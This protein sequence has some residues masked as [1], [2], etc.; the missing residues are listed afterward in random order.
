MDREEKYADAFRE[1]AAELLSDMEEVILSLETDPRD[2]ELINRL[3]RI[4]HT[5]KGSGAMFGFQKV[6]DF[7]HHLETMLDLVRAGSMTVTPALISLLLQSRDHIQVM[8]YSHGSEPEGSAEQGSA[9]LAGLKTLQGQPLQPPVS[10]SGEPVHPGSITAP[11]LV[12][13]AEEPAV[14][15][16]QKDKAT[17]NQQSLSTYRLRI[18]LDPKVM[19]SGLD[20][21]CLLREL[22][23]MGECSISAQTDQVPWLDEINPEECYFYW[24]AIINTAASREDL[25]MV[26]L[27]VEDESQISITRLTDELDENG[28]HK[29]LGEILVER[30]DISKEDVRNILAKQKRAGELMV[31]AGLVTPGKIESA[32]AEQKM[33]QQLRG[34]QQQNTDTIRVST[35][36]L[37]RLINLVGEMVITQAQLSQTS[38]RYQDTDLLTPVENIERL[39]NELRDCALNIRMFP[40][41][42]TFSKFRR[43]VHDL[44]ASLGKEAEL[45]TEGGE[46]E[47]DKTVIER[48]HDPLIHLIRN[49]LD[50]GLESPEERLKAGKPACGTIRLSAGQSGGE[51]IITIEDDGAG[52]DR[53][54]IRAKGIEQGLISESE[55]LTDQQVFNL[56]FLPGFSTASKITDVSGRGVG[57]DVV[58]REISK[59]RGSVDINSQRGRGTKTSIHLPLT[60]AI[61]EGLLV[62]VG[63]SHYVVPLTFVQECV[64]LTSQEVNRAH[65][66]HVI[67]L[68]GEIIPYIRLREVFGTCR[69]EESMP[70][71]EYVVVAMVEGKR[72]GL[73][74]DTIIGDY[75][76][77]I[78]SLG[79]IYEHTEGISGATILGDGTI[80]LIVD[81]RQLIECAY[82][83]EREVLAET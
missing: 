3:F 8:L 82:R 38:N 4:M 66:R 44:S 13:P 62:A 40:I 79:R 7:A 31:E 48:I 72:V 53:E 33:V 17:S 70:P 42:G 10:S 50:H 35:K 19:L 49:S 43:L 25:E 9:I 68:R 34:S 11:A 29:K 58:R 81:V 32:L 39:T 14:C 56:I 2:Q 28:E 41:E 1:E 60:L 54:R 21:L 80:A 18:K 69:G 77:V 30:G 63:S 15:L 22:D 73:V 12:S 71:I 64:E 45:I 36:K 67:H 83:Q 51:V 59:L 20:P 5:I 76:A 37:D 16:P 78:K 55:N 65:G 52:L 61:I 75:Q 57:M 26:F 6:A 23:S 46:T 24:D 74:T 47:L 27:F